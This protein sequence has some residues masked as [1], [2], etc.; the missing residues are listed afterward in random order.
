MKWH[1]ICSTEI[2]R[3]GE[4]MYLSLYNAD[5]ISG[6]KRFGK[7]SILSVIYQETGD[8]RKIHQRMN[9]HVLIARITAQTAGSAELLLMYCFGV[10]TRT[11]TVAQRKERGLKLDPIG[12]HIGSKF[13]FFRPN[14]EFMFYL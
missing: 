10:Q 2:L 14:C 7:T 1:F 6:G 9:E 13:F 5:G 3:L 11:D 4:R 8:T 12:G